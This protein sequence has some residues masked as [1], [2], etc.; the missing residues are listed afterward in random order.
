MVLYQVIKKFFA[1]DGTPRRILQLTGAILLLS[2]LFAVGFYFAERR[3][4]PELEFADAI[5]WAMVS[6]TTV[7]YGDYYAQTA[8]GRFLISFPAFILGIGF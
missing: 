5:W 2:V 3:V 8:V 4:N 7:G 1:P 6:L